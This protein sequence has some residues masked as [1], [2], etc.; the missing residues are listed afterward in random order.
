MHK[1]VEKKV[2]ASTIT[3]LKVEAPMVVREAKPGQFVIVRLN[4]FA[5]RIP[6]TICDIDKAKGHLTMIIQE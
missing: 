6:L 5:E 3:L 4:E 1:V 2:L